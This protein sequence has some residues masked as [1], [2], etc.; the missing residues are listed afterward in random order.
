MNNI[1]KIRVTKSFTFD[2]AHALYGYDGPCKNIHG[3]TYHLDITLLGQP[4]ADIEHVKLGMVI[5]F[6][7]LKSIVQKLIIEVF[8]H[9]L[10]LNEEAP[11]SKSEVISNEFEKVILVPFQPTCENLLLHFVDILKEKFSD[12]TQLLSISLKETPTSSAS[13]FLSDN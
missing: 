12:E 8:D 11:Y 6:G 10:V 3:H 9:A 5:D 7:D 1:P 13:W 4:I 2:M